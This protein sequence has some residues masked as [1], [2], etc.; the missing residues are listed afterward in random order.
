MSKISSG[1][2]L[3]TD[4]FMRNFYKDNR[5]A[6]QRN[7]RGNYTKLELSYEDSRALS[8]ASKRMISTDFGTGEDEEESTDI[9][10]T[11]ISKIKAFADTYNNALDSGDMDNYDSKRYI[12]QLKSL[13]QK[14]ADEL[15]EIGITVGQDGKLTVDE[16]LLS[17]ADSSQVRK[18]FSDEN[19]FSRKSL[20]IAK[21]LNAVAHDNLLAQMNGNGMRINITL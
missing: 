2:T 9:D 21:Q 16:N 17:M 15:G 3:T 4:Y 10:E 12:K 11:M 19:D 14:Y 7:G 20:S 8:R 5:D 18:V 1:L 13:G 6:A